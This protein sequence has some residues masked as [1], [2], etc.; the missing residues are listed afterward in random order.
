MIHAAE[1]ASAEPSSAAPTGR[2]VTVAF[3]VALIAF[4]CMGA[5]WATAL[6]P[7]GTYDEV[8]HIWRAYGVATGQIYTHGGIQRVPRS[9]VPGNPNCTWA[10]RKTAACQTPVWHDATPVDKV[11]TAAAYSP[12]Y[13]LPVGLP[14]VAFKDHTGLLLGRY[15]SV[16]LSALALAGALAVAVALRNRLMVG[17]VLLVATPMTLNLAG[18]IN[19]NGLEISC[20]VLLWAALLGLVRPPGRELSERLTHRLVV[21][22]AISGSLLLTIRYFG[23]VLLAIS[24]GAAALLAHRGRVREL[25]RRRDV[26]ITGAVLAAALVVAAFWI[27]S[28]N[29]A[30]IQDTQGRRQHLG[31]G[32]VLRLILTNR[33]PFWTNQ[34][35]GQFSYGETVLPSWLIV[36][37]Y[38]LVAALVI[39]ALLLAGRRLRWTVVGLGV[40]CFAILVG[41]EVHFVNSVGWVSHGRYIMPAGAGV[42]LA[43]AFV[44]R[45]R[46]ALG[47]AGSARLAR[48][49]V[50]GTLPAHLW[51]LAAV[52]TRFEAGPTALM[53]PLHGLRHADPNGWLPPGGPIPPLVLEILGLITLGI[54]GWRL[55]TW[56]DRSRRASV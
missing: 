40:A 55:V 41:L 2:R 27:I 29:S 19:P 7:N 32:Q 9:L 46:A 31:Y 14:M 20:G 16:L 50:V 51:A 1:Q 36:G 8:P 22:A 3:L 33:M 37:W 44:G 35:V 54:L 5:G 23:P 17:A 42:V 53:N 18:A 30:D 43:A 39:P 34:L 45:W 10:E 56:P 25:L 48:L 11:S 13:Y 28:S 47:E 52:M 4:F 15:V 21:L 12:I 24:L 6:P 26:R 38:A 49:I